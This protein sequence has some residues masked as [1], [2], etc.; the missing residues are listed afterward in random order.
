MSVSVKLIDGFQRVLY[1]EF[2]IWV[3]FVQL[4][5]GWLSVKKFLITIMNVVFFSLGA[6]ALL[7]L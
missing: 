7:D 6:Q 4:A 1:G 3:S 2:V 5:L